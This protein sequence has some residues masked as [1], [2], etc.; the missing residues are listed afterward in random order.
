[1]RKWW[2][3]W[4]PRVVERRANRDDLNR[5]RIKIYG[6]G[7]AGGSATIVGRDGNVL[8]NSPGE[9]G[10]IKGEGG[11]GGIA[12]SRFNSPSGLS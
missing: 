3:L 7:G 12:T 11:A 4:K 8:M 9:P 10:G 6:S 5:V 2:Q 1:M